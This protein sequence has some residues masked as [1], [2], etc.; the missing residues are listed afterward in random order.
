MAEGEAPARQ[1]L[2]DE[3]S[4]SVAILR[5]PNAV[6]AC[7][8]VKAIPHR[9][10]VLDT[11]VHEELGEAVMSRLRVPSAFT[12]GVESKVHTLYHR[13][14]IDGVYETMIVCSPRAVAQRVRIRRFVST[15]T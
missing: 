4:D 10:D 6:H 2:C 12:F 1:V 7:C 15:S 8:I 11:C 5:R 9:Y 3:E 14:K 13:T